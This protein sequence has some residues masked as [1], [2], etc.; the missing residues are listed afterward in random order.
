MKSLINSTFGF[1]ESLDPL[2]GSGLL[3]KI[4]FQKNASRTDFDP[5][6]DSNFE[7]GWNP[8]VELLIY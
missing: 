4:Q 6:T 2:S 8:K 1:Q 7:L 5:D 3:S